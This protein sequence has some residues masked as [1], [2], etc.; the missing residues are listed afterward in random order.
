MGAAGTD[1]WADVAIVKDNVTGSSAPRPTS[2]LLFPL[3]PWEP[4]L[5]IPSEYL[6]FLPAPPNST[7]ASGIGQVC[8]L[9]VC[10]LPKNHVEI[11]TSM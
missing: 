10:V 1:V 7:L 3:P 4:K 8:G 6:E 2:S 11:L 9:N 5:D